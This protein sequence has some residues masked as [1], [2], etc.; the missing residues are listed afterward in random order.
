MTERSRQA[1]SVASAQPIR[2]PRIAIAPPSATLSGA[3]YLSPHASTLPR[4]ND[5]LTSPTYITDHLPSRRLSEIDSPM[6]LPNLL[7]STADRPLRNYAPISGYSTTPLRIRTDVSALPRFVDTSTDYGNIGRDYSRDYVRERPITSENPR[8]DFIRLSEYPATSAVI[9]L[10]PPRLITP[11]LDADESKSMNQLVPETTAD[12]DRLALYNNSSLGYQRLCFLLSRYPAIAMTI[13]ATWMLWGRGLG[14]SSV[15]SNENVCYIVSFVAGA[16]IL[17]SQVVLTTAHGNSYKKEKI[18]A[19][20]YHFSNT[21]AILISITVIVF[22]AI[23]FQDVNK[24]NHKTDTCTWMSAPLNLGG[25]PEFYCFTPQERQTF[26]SILI[27]ASGLVIILYI[28]SG[29]YGCVGQSLMKKKR[30]DEFKQ[31]A[32]AHDNAAFR[33]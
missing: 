12:V 9:G 22:A 18:L 4:S 1:Q 19:N 17:S 28:F 30:Q 11:V 13:I 3:H 31:Y 29:I 7:S 25:I 21:V 23:S 2:I 27:G 32:E 15:K 26:L 33:F 20:L 24:V 5:V 14:L 10:Q 6:Y 16:F 8:D